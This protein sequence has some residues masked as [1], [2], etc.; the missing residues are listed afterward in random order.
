MLNFADPDYG[1][2]SFDAGQQARLQAVFGSGVCD[3]TKPGVGQ[4]IGQ[5]W[6]TFKDGPGGVPLPPP[7]ESVRVVPS[8][9]GTT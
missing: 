6:T 9:A 2:V 8:A 3:W 1:G 7:P 4:V 5:P